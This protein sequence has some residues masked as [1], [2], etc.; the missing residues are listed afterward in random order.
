VNLVNRLAAL[1]LVALLGQAP[2]DRPPGPA[3]VSSG[4]AADA[5]HGGADLRR[6]VLFGWVSPP[7]SITTDARLA[8]MAGVGLNVAVTAWNDSGHTADNLVR[9]DLAAA[10]GMRCLVWDERFDR[11]DSLEVDSPEGGVLL[12]SIV[13]DYRGHPGF[14]GYSLGDEPPRERWPLL[15]KLFPALL[16]RDPECLPW[17]N[18]LG[19]MGFEGRDDWVGYGRA[20]LSAMHP[21]VLCNDHYEFRTVGDRGQFIE[22]AAGLAALAREAGIPFWAIVLLIQHG[23]YRAVTPGELS[24]QVSMLLAY[25]AHGIGY[26]TYWTPAPDTVWDW[27]PAVIT[28]GGERTVWYPVLADLNRRVRPV[29][30]TLASL[31][32][33]AT[34]HVGWTPAGGTP[35][36]PDGLIAAVEGRAALGHFVD[37]FGTRHVLVVNS[38][39]LASQRVTLTVRITQ[40][41]WMLGESAGDWRPLQP[42]PSPEGLRVALDLAPGGFTLLRFGGSLW[43]LG[44]GSGPRLRVAPRPARGEVRLSVSALDPGGHVEI[45]DATGRRVRSWRPATAEASL[46]WRGERDSGGFA[47]PGLYFVR[48]EDGGGVSVSR[49]EWLGRN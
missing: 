23:D 35:F 4:P 48:A 39:S 29:G 30:E 12:D 47:P 24:W 20:Y 25:G 42:R 15:A 46:V 5:R 8:E 27:H 22:N 33:L 16:Q 2:G 19:R 36:A 11:F 37:A 49:I 45:L 34:G 13:A 17:N 26:F 44:A 6:F 31:T 21:R 9:L 14:L 32:W 41:L 18:L 40:G 1:V 10:R 38:D 7:A 28:Y 3:R 43:P